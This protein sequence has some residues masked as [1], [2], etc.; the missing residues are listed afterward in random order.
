MEVREF[1]R[2]IVENVFLIAMREAQ[3][4]L[5]RGGEGVVFLGNII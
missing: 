2:F 5:A 1:L 3:I 4:T